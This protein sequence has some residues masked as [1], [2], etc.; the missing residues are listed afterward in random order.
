[1]RSKYLLK[2]VLEQ[3]YINFY[4]QLNEVSP[5]EVRKRMILCLFTTPEAK[6]YKQQNVWSL[7][8]VECLIRYL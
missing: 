8:I 4:Q 1:M 3:L 6:L 2:A 7:F 5:P